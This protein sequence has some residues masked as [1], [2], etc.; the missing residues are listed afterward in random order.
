[1]KNLILLLTVLISSSTIAQNVVNVSYY[2][3]PREEAAQ[4][5]R[6]HQKF[7]DLQMS[8]DRLIKG[9]GLFTHVQADNYTYVSYEFYDSVA[10]LEKDSSI[11]SAALKANTA[12]LDLSKKERKEL[13]AEYQKYNSTIFYNHYDQIRMG[14]ADMNWQFETA[15]WT[16]K[17]ITTLSK[18]NIKEGMQ[19]QFFET[20]KNGEFKTKKESGHVEAI[21]GSWH[22]FGSGH[23]IHVYTFF[24]NWDNF[25]AFEKASAYDVTQDLGENE[26]KFWASVESH[27]DEILMFI[28]GIDQSTGKFYFAK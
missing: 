4:F 28:G 25:A 2:K 6:S 24:D 15:D 3:V 9:G 10:D 18:F 26:K 1:M 17:K 21:T 22:L 8:K 23:H 27:E 13:V 20:W 11:E 7:S 19:K 5:V 16:K 12:A 14:N